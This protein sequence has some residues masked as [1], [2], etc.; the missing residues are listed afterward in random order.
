MRDIF[1]LVRDPFFN[2]N[3]AYNHSTIP[4]EGTRVKKG[5]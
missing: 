1:S 5:R 2:W 3:D 4:E